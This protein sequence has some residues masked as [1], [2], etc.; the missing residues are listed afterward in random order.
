MTFLI[1]SRIFTSLK[2]SRPPPSPVLYANVTSYVL[3]EG[4]ASQ[5]FVWLD[6]IALFSRA[7][8]SIQRT[9]NEDDRN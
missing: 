9:D 5:V 1:D 3:C 7:L 4:R 8:L 2:I 6:F